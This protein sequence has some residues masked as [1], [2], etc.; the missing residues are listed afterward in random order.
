[1]GVFDRFATVGSRITLLCCLLLLGGVSIAFFDQVMTRRLTQ[2]VTVPEMRTAV[3]EGRRSLIQ[4]VIDTQI[5]TISHQLA[6]VKEQQKQYEIIERCTDAVRYFEDNS[7]YVFAYKIDGTRINMPTNKADN[8]KNF[9]SLTDPKGKHLIRELID[10]AKSGGGFVD[11]VFEKPGQGIQPKVSYAEQIPGTDVVIGTGV[12]LDNVDRQVEKLVT[13]LDVES[14]KVIRTQIVIGGLLFGVLLTLAWLITRSI[15]RVMRESVTKLQNAAEHTAA[16]ADQV[17]ETSQSLAAS[18]SKQAEL[19]TRTC[20]ALQ[21]VGTKITSNS[22]DAREVSS[23]ATDAANEASAGD[24]AMARMNEAISAIESSSVQT[25]KIISVI[26]EIAF[27][28]N[29]LALN[30]AVEAARAGEAGKGFAVVAE[31]VRSLA[32]RSAE[33][34]ADTTKLLQASG[35][36][37]RNGVTLSGRVGHTLESIGTATGTVKT[38]IAQIVASSEQQVAAVTQV[39]GDLG[40]A[41]AAT[42]SNAAAAEESAAASEELSAQASELQAI[43]KTLIRLVG[44]SATEPSVSVSRRAA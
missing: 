30:A 35:E 16:A 21:E 13:A 41:D 19:I 34:A 25:A 22:G 8:G 3:L 39:I 7:G 24:Q 40:E 15:T 14:Q 32:T 20:N 4:A 2:T 36:A 28:T 18:A 11:Y 5:G 23:V 43:S 9:L 42:Q 31:E 6:G 38:R 12:Y 29:L 10:A 26:N 37:A 17:S 33:A 1:M 44:G 27:Q